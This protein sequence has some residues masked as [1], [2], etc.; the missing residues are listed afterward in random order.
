MIYGISFWM[1]IG[2][3]TEEKTYLYEMGENPL[4]LLLEMESKDY[5]DNPDLDLAKQ[6]ENKGITL[7]E[8]MSELK[9]GDSWER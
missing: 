3:D 8:L 6:F 5:F 9:F 7:E 4:G 2:Y 1:W